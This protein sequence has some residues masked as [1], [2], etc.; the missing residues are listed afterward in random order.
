MDNA[1]LRI[2]DQQ[3]PISFRVVFRDRGTV[4][5]IFEQI[6]EEKPNFLRFVQRLSLKAFGIAGIKG[7]W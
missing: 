7:R 2:G 6:K 1:V 4:G 3:Y 5:V